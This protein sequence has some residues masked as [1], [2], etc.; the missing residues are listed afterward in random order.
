[1]DTAAGIRRSPSEVEFFDR[2][3]LNKDGTSLLFSA[4]QPVTPELTTTSIASRRD[5]RVRADRITARE[6]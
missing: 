2:D 1:M 6:R 3:P 5:R 4:V